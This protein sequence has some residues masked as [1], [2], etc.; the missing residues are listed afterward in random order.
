MDRSSK[1]GEGLRGS[2][3]S[4]E[5]MYP[6]LLPPLKASHPLF[7]HSILQH[8]V[9]DQAPRTSSPNLKKKKNSEAHAT[10]QAHQQ[11]QI[12]KN[13]N[14]TTTTTTKGKPIGREPKR[15]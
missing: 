8:E 12:K 14:S 10:L 1:R 9:K 11:E 4:T 13:V 7:L 15:T 3:R 6:L 2:R 5:P